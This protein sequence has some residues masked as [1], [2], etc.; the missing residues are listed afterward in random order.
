MYAAP[1]HQHL[2]IAKA[3]Q[4]ENVPRFVTN[5]KVLSLRK[6]ITQEIDK[7]IVIPME[8]PSVGNLFFKGGSIDFPALRN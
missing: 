4:N 2:L 5:P 7:N 3:A 6:I 1:E 8:I